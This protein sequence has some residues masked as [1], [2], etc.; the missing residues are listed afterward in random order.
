MSFQDR[1]KKEQAKL[2]KALEARLWMA[3]FTE[4]SDGDFIHFI[5]QKLNSFGIKSSQKIFTGAKQTDA[6]WDVL[7]ENYMKLGGLRLEE[8]ICTKVRRETL[9]SHCRFFFA[10]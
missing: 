9:S 5:V 2:C 4:L 3:H 6:E 7:C 10:S 8:I 1:L